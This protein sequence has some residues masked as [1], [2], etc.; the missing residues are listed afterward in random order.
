MPHEFESGVFTEG[1]PAWHGLGVTLPN[2]G[3]DA[4]KPRILHQTQHSADSDTD[5]TPIRKGVDGR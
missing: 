3:L 1:R 2:E 5:D 4:T